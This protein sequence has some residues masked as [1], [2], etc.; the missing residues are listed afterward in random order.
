MGQQVESWARG[1]DPQPMPAAPAAPQQMAFIDGYETLLYV[2]GAYYDRIQASPSWRSEHFEVQRSQINLHA[3]VADVAA[4][5]IALRSVRVDLDRAMRNGG[6]DQQFVDHIAAKRAGLA[7]GVDAVARTRP[8]SRRGCARDGF[9]RRRTA[10]D[11]R[12][13]PCDDDRRPDRRV[14]VALG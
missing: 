4:D 6:F 1:A 7:P 2:V 12:V 9:G 5:I 13:R 8:G 10:A 11:R 14:G 3:D